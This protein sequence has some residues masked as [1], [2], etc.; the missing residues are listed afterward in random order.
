MIRFD[1]L[2]YQNKKGCLIK[3]PFYVLFYVRSV[4]GSV[5]VRLG[6]KYSLKIKKYIGKYCCFLKIIAK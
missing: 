1:L 5:V 6:Y 4:V 3:H 2:L